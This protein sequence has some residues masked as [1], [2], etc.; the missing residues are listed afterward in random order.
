MTGFVMIGVEEREDGYDKFVA[1][2]FN[3]PNGQVTTLE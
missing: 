1:D 3:K 2:E